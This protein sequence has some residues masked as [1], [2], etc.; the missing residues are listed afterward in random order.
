MLCLNHDS[1]HR[2]STFWDLGKHT[3]KLANPTIAKSLGFF[4][5]ISEAMVQYVEETD[6]QYGYLSDH[7]MIVLKFS[8]GKETKRK[9]FWKFDSTLLKDSAYLNEIN[10]EIKKVVEEYAVMLYN[11]EKS[12]IRYR[13]MIFNLLYAINCFLMFC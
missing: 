9:T 5:I 8:F 10:E 13:N 11:R 12:Y 4:F 7:S 1:E 3:H 6:I 2:G